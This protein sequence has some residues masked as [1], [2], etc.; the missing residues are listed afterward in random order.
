M[1]PCRFVLVVI[2]GSI[3]FLVLCL[4]SATIISEEEEE[5][6]NYDGET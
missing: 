2:L 4:V 3:A 6:I 5:R 1:N